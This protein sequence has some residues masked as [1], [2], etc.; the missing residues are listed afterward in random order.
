MAG[1]APTMVNA[2]LGIFSLTI[3]KAAIMSG[4]PLRFQ[5]SPTKR[6]FGCA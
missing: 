2:A 1:S 5:S 3:L 6:I 4:P